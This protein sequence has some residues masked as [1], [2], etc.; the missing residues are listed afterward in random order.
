MKSYIANREDAYC[1][2]CREQCDISL[3]PDGRFNEVYLSRCC[4]A[5]LVTIDGSV[6]EPEIIQGR[7]EP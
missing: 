5:D 4:S 3:E 7:E 1:R 2:D 6:F